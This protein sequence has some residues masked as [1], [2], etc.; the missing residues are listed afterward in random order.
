M[1]PRHT[2]LRNELLGIWKKMGLKEGA[3]LQSQNEIVKS[4]GYSLSTVIKTLKDLEHEGI[5]E[6]KVGLG[7][8]LK[9]EVWKNNHLRVGFFYN[10]NT[11]P[12]GVLNSS[13]YGSMMMELEKKL[14]ESGDELIF[15]SFSHDNLHIDLWNQLDAVVL[16]G[17]LKDTKFDFSKITSPLFLM[18]SE[19]NNRFGDSFS[20]DFSTAFKDMS[21][22]IKE[23]GLKKVLYIDSVHKTIQQE[24]RKRMFEE[25]IVASN[26]KLKIKYCS[27]DVEDGIDSIDDLLKQVKDFQPQVVCGYIHLSW[28]EHI[29]KKSKGVKVFPVDSNSSSKRAFYIDMNTWVSELIDKIKIRISDRSLSN[30]KYF[31]KVKFLCQ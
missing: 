12:K 27:G 17:I 13:F 30:K 26:P 28:I 21:S 29:E 10:R 2:L 1:Q 4:C 25:K 5:I 31:H 16:T 18:D 15:G 22:T 24:S 7:S 9:K 23:T 11:V 3:P 20:L 8:F 19:G 6:R 14:I